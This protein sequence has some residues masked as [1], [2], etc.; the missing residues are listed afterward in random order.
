[1][2]SGK[3]AFQ[4]PLLNRS[5]DV[6]AA[7][8]SSLYTNHL[9]SRTQDRISQRA[10]RWFSRRATN[11]SGSIQSPFNSTNRDSNA[12]NV[13][14]LREAAE[15]LL[16]KFSLPG[17]ICRRPL[18]LISCLTAVVLTTSEVVFRKAATA[19]MFHYRWFLVQLLSFLTVLAYLATMSVKPK[20][21]LRVFW[22]GSDDSMSRSL[23][24]SQ[25]DGTKHSPLQSTLR[26]NTSGIEDTQRTG[27][28]PN[29]PEGV[30]Y[31]SNSGSC[32]PKWKMTLTD[33]Y[34]HVRKKESFRATWKSC[35]AVALLDC[36]H[37][38][39][40][41]IPLGVVPGPITAIL[42]YLSVAAGLGLDVI[43]CGWDLPAPPLSCFSFVGATIIIIG[44]YIYLFNGSFHFDSM[45]SDQTEAALVLMAIGCLPL[46]LSN[47]IKRHL[48]ASKQVDCAQLNFWVSLLS[49]VFG[50]ALCNV[51]FSIQ[52]MGSDDTPRSGYNSLSQHLVGGFK[53]LLGINTYADDFCEVAMLWEIVVF[54]FSMAGSRLS[55]FLI[56]R[57]S[58]RETF[59]H[60]LSQIGTF[61]ACLAMY[62]DDVRSMWSRAFTINGGPVVYYALP[63]STSSVVYGLLL[64]FL[65]VWLITRR[66]DIPALETSEEE[67]WGIGEEKQP[68]LCPQQDVDDEVHS[69]YKGSVS[70]P[71][72][73]PN[74]QRAI[75][76]PIHIA[77][78]EESEDDV[79]DILAIEDNITH[80]NPGQDAMDRVASQTNLAGLLDTPGSS[81]M[82][83]SVSK[84]SLSGLLRT[85]KHPSFDDMNILT[86]SYHMESL[87][88]CRLRRARTN[89]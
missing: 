6:S 21:L 45:F 87:E 34:I 44:L 22:S 17:F 30:S 56:L 28:L 65:G 5:N 35:V 70:R 38:F 10:P 66:A 58:R 16:N 81:K 77:L 39:L 33:T 19:N 75:T 80:S 29:S 3:K 86:K 41:F 47:A 50:F 69:V 14:R 24:S 68:L 2:T 4:E 18:N 23:V 1:M 15:N 40:V 79:L 20:K 89:L 62:S 12:S 54:L 88:Q 32:T 72:S 55:F 42:P 9:L 48:L 61:V 31:S 71:P 82:V 85:S 51:G 7:S 78:Q 64:L 52:Y 11:F 46:V 43:A 84:G 8:E 74:L 59:V 26:K 57:D 63:A 25:S 83:K 67:F 37:L 53:C 60:Q 13:S 76:I 49:C 27:L 36:L 73:F